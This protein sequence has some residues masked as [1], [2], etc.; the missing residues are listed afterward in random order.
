MFGLMKP[1]N[2]G[3]NK[4]TK[5]DYRLHYCGT[6]KTI[7][8]NFSQKSRLLLNNDIVFLGQLLSIISGESE[9][10][11]NWNKAYFSN[12]C[13]SMPL[14]EQNPISLEFAAT[15]NII[16]AELK[17][18]DNISDTIK[19]NRLVWKLSKSF[20][21]KE[22]K[23]AEKIM[24]QWSFPIDHLWDLVYLQ[25]KRES[26]NIQLNS[27]REKLNYFAETTA[28][29]T[30]ISFKKGAEVVGKDQYADQMYKLG[31]NFGRIVYILDA[32][33][34]YEKDIKD[35][36]FNAIKSSFKTDDTTVS[37]EIKNQVNNILTD[38]KEENKLILNSL[39]IPEDR[40]E[41]FNKQLRVNLGKRLMINISNTCNAFCSTN[42]NSEDT[43]NKKSSINL[44]KKDKANKK[45]KKDNKC[46]DCD[47]TGCDL[48]TD[49]C[50]DAPKIF[51]RLGSCFRCHALDDGCHCCHSSPCD[52]ICCSCN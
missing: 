48:C 28:A 10:K 43:I 17:I 27:E 7:G 12:N 41:L 18:D 32:L 8:S 26:E 42:D 36:N 30:G 24:K 51:H 4:E 9:N 3:T 34:D 14:V 44:N 50:C 6:C 45:K 47:C 39:D 15:L 20:L 49:C 37:L 31:N 19:K 22:F 23:K 1:A 25:K 29:M 21:S 33:E 40:K 38:L 5:A 2:C 13:M 11:L 35:N 46:D 52:D 16:L